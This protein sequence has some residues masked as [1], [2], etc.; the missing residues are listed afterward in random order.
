MFTTADSAGKFPAYRQI[1]L[2]PS[3]SEW[4]WYTLWFPAAM[5]LAMLGINQHYLKLLVKIFVGVAVLQALLA[6]VQFGQGSDS[7]LRF[8][9]PYYSGSGVGTYV[10]RNHLAALL[11]MA[12]PLVLAL[13]ANS[14]GSRT[15]ESR[16]G[17]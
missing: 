10:S 16:R 13:L 9:N 15:R 7:P 11:Y 12:L 5:F 3:N 1:S 2:I 17:T 8:G 6:L 4:G 14:I